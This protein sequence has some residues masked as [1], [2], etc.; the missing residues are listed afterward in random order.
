MYRTQNIWGGGSK[1]NLNGLLF[2]RETSLNELLEANGY[3]IINEEIYNEDNV[4]IGLSIPKYK[5]YDY[6]NERKINYKDYISKKWLPDE[7]FLNYKTRTIYIIEKKYQNSNGSVDEK[8]TNCDFKR[9]EYQKLFTPL[10]IKVKYLYLFNDWFK[11]EKYIDSLK[12]IE[13]MG[14]EY[15]FNEIPFESIGLKKD[16]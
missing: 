12:Y 16:N 2:E 9:K 15:Y 1:T 13:D 14:C 8:L 6:L 11:K 10:K 3:N 4:L 5:L 7:A